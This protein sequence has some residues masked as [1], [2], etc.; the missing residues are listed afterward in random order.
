MAVTHNPAGY[1]GTVDQVDEARRFALGGGGRFRVST[2]ADWTPTASSSTNRTVNIAAGAGQ[3][4][5]VYDATTSSDS[6]VFGANTGS[7]DRLD[8]VVA[9]FDWTAKTVAF[10]VI[11]GTSTGPPGVNGGTGTAVD[12]T[13]INR[14]PG[15]RYDAL[16]AVVRARPGVTILAGADLTDCRVWG[17]WAGLQTASAAFLSSID[18]D[19][20]HRLRV[21]ADGIE[22]ISMADGSFITLPRIFVQSAQP[23]TAPNG[24]LWFQTP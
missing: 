22:Y 18:L 12:V 24:S 14:L 6:V 10:G 3:G 21:A 20:G 15:I 2:S 19:P 11:A 23:S 13:K 1:A 17:S 8:A 9:T 4:C 5:G 16:L 7:V